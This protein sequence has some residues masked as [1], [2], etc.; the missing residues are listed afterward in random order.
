MPNISVDEYLS[1]RSLS[2][3]EGVVY[4]AAKMPRSFDQATRSATFIMTDETTDSYGDTV[5]AKG[6][7]LSRFENNPI[8]L[9]N[10]R[11]DLILG[12]WSD[13]A[14][15]SKRLEGKA[16][17]AAE[18]TAPHVDMSYNLMSQGILRAASIGFMP[19]KLERKLDEKGEPTWAYNILEWELYECSIV[20]IPANPSALAKSVKDGNV[21]A[22]D[23]IESV[24]DTYAKTASGLIVPLGELEAAH[25]DATGNRTIITLDAKVDA[26]TWLGE[27]RQLTERMERAAKITGGDE[28]P[29]VQE[30]I[31][32]EVAK[33]LEEGVERALQEVQTKIDD[34]PEEQVERRGAFS[35]LMDGIR[36]LIKGKDAE[37][38][39]APEKANPD[40]V[41]ALM[42]EAEEIAARHVEA[43]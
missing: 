7:D 18:G 19:K 26:P 30:V 40:E 22:L 33:E 15:K 34:I 28:A 25:R 13:V 24:L 42:R 21:M 35:K 36:G 27:V 12:T 14:L 5:V 23:F 43:A 11:S 3:N 8:C 32:D 16:T 31:V 9:L 2:V 20:S 38:E 4:R 39:P 10:H 29:E 41:A 6:A 17:L 1:K 37:P